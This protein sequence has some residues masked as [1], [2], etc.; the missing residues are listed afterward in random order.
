[1]SAS[2][3]QEPVVLDAASPRPR[4]VWPLPMEQSF[5]QE[6]LTHLFTDYWSRITF[7]PILHGA[8]YEFT[9]PTPPSAIDMNAGF[10][11]VRFGTAHFHLCLGTAN[12]TDTGSLTPQPHHPKQARLFRQLD[13]QGAPIAWGF[14]MISQVDQ[15]MLTI[16]FDSPFAAPGDQLLNPPQWERL[17]MWR[18]IAWRYLH[19]PPESFDESGKGFVDGNF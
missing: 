6:L 3:P 19:R 15:P 14:E 4:Q 7:G 8:A 5:L 17:S 1:M 18:A 9:C 12:P 10:L 2:V 11:T 13:P 16:Y